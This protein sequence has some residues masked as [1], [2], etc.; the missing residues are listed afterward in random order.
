MEETEDTPKRF[1]QKS[2][3]LRTVSTK[4]N[5]I[6]CLHHGKKIG[7]MNLRKAAE[8]TA[9]MC[10]V[11]SREDYVHSACREANESI[12]HLGDNLKPKFISLQKKVKYVKS[13]TGFDDFNGNVI[14]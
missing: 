13:V 11:S 5:Y 12:L 14:L 4:I 8:V 3:H 6:Q 7:Y 2:P 10:R 9:E 1:C